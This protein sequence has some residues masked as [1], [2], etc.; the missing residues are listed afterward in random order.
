MKKLHLI[1]AAVLVSALLTVS[2]S[3]KQEAEKKPEKQIKKE[4]VKPQPPVF[5]PEDSRMVAR[6]LKNIITQLKSTERINQKRLNTL[7]ESLNDTRAAMAGIVVLTAL[8]VILL[9]YYQNRAFRNLKKG[10]AITAEPDSESEIL[11]QNLKT[12]RDRVDEALK[13]S[14]LLTEK[15]ATARPLKEHAQLAGD[16][17]EN[18]SVL[19]ALGIKPTAEMHLAKGLDAFYQKNTDKAGE[20]FAK[21]LEADDKSFYGHYF[22]SAVKAAEKDHEASLK[23]LSKAVELKPESEDALMQKSYLLLKLKPEGFEEEAEKT[24]NK[25]LAVN[26][27]NADAYHNLGLLSL[28]KQDYG[29]ACEMFEK[30]VGAD[31]KKSESYY[32]L[33]C[34]CALN[35]EGEKSLDA[36]SEAVNLKSTY[37]AKA[38][39]DKD[40]E[41]IA[42]TERFREITGQK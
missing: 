6:E 10:D 35:G 42:D 23:H 14:D 18:I 9:I 27:E 8:C 29:K 16:T 13:S 11:L 39:K 21:A 28:K 4:V 25:A 41:S 17:A 22:M 5:S 36:L 1:L 32:N 20:H 31:E 24:L 26:S 37:K 34:A 15:S 33:A 40:L 12:L 2:C 19:Q 7:E 3:D 30:A 38:L